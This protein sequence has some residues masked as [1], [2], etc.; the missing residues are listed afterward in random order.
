MYH[1]ASGVVLY[2]N[3]LPSKLAVDSTDEQEL[4]RLMQRNGYT[5]EEARARMATQIPL[6]EKAARADIV[7]D[8]TQSLA[9]TRKQVCTI[10]S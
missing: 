1:P 4:V 5:E 6:G 8:N 3:P 9:H 2:S 10:L 7:L